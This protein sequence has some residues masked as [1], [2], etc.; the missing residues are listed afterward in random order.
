MVSL[1]GF[2]RVMGEEFNLDVQE[3]RADSTLE[4]DCGLD[5]LGM[6]ELLLLVEDLGPVISE[7][8]LL[9]WRTVGDVYRSMVTNSEMSSGNPAGARNPLRVAHHDASN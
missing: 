3:L 4:E 2:L 9:G 8:D 1:E 7:G 5:S 6:Y